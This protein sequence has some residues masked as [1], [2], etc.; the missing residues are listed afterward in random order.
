MTYANINTLVG[1]HYLHPTCSTKWAAGHNSANPAPK[2]SLP[3][4]FLVSTHLCHIAPRT[5]QSCC[6]AWVSNVPSRKFTAETVVQIGG[7]L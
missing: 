6:A 7:H 2:R 1:K 4:D 3:D 5:S